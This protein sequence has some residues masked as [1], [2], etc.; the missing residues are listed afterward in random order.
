MFSGSNSMR[1]FIHYALF[2]V[3]FSAERRGPGRDEQLARHLITQ[4]DS[5]LVLYSVPDKE[6]LDD[7][8]A[9]RNSTAL[10]GSMIDVN[11]FGS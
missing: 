1:R 6:M 2:H 11:N 10:S 7:V 9:C 4:Y 8:S 3:S 5:I